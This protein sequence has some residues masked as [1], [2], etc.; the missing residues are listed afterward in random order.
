MARNKPTTSRQLIQAII[1]RGILHEA[2]ANRISHVEIVCDLTRMAEMKVTYI[3]DD[4][5]LNLALEDVAS[6]EKP[7]GE[8]MLCPGIRLQKTSRRIWR[9]VTSK[10]G[11]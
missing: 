7:E 4:R 5:M 3:V 9:S 2:D 8:R 1:D 10:H 11:T 6:A